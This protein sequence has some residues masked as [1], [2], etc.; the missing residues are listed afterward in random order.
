[1]APDAGGASAPPG[2]LLIATQCFPPRTGGIETLLH[3]LAWAF[4]ERGFAVTVFAD[5]LAAREDRRFDQSQPYPIRR[6][7]GPRPWRRRRK[8]RA[9]HDLAASTGVRALITDSW[10]SLEFLELP[11]GLPV[12]CLAH[13][14]EFPLRC[15]AAKRR[16]IRASLR[17]ASAIAANSSF[18]ADRLRPFVDDPGRVHVI[19]P[20]LRQPLP[21]G[22][23]LPARIA[24]GA[25]QRR[26]LLV[27]VARLER[28]KGIDKALRILPGLVARHPR[29]LYVIGGEGSQKAGLVRLAGML[30][31]ENH[32]HFAGPLD[33]QAK[34]AWLGCADLF[35]LPGALEDDDVEGFGIVFLEAGWFGVPAVAG[36]TGGVAE[37]VIDG[38]S[39][40]LVDTEDLAALEK[41]V[42][43]LLG[44]AGRRQRL[45]EEARRRARARLW[46]RV[47]RE[48]QALLGP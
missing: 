46:D 26:P 25:E 29:L 44:D 14:S 9:I 27:T 15:G 32:V 13:G 37:A 34:S 43:D 11:R 24:D 35:L 3:S 10:K 40:V 1:M 8:A 31:L 7:A 41:A 22:A 30:G 16:R 33:E 36:R 47:I 20:G 45:G 23:T 18:T 5:R 21:A 39:G 6:F 48:Y 4:A 42:A 28:R 19:H 2:T 38:E 17:R 12:L